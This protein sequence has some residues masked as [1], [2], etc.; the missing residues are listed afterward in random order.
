MILHQISPIRGA[1][2]Y[3]T[4]ENRYGAPRSGHSHAGQDVLAACGTPLVAARGGKVVEAGYEGPRG[5]A[6]ALPG[7]G[8]NLAN[9]YTHLPDPPR[10]PTRPP[11]A[12]GP[13]HRCRRR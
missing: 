11:R 12:P 9:G 8:R 3:G 7:P 13:A 2:N 5:N 10:V 6:G 4:A 1:H